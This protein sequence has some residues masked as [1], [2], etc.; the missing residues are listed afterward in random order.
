MVRVQS[1]LDKEEAASDMSLNCSPLESVISWGDMSQAACWDDIQQW[2]ETNL[3]KLGTAP[4]SFV[5]DGK[6]SEVFLS[7]W[8]FTVTE[9]P[10]DE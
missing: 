5:Y 4:F 9:V 7:D 6:I 10:L 2:I 3:S 8:D 1:D